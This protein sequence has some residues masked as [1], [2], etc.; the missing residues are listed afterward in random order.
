[1][2]DYYK[3]LNVNK[4]SSDKEIKKA[5]HKLALKHHPDHGGDVNKFKEINEAF[6][7]ISNQDKRKKY[8]FQRNG[9]PFNG[10]PD[11]NSMMNE[12]F[13]GS[14]NNVRQR[15][16]EKEQKD[17]DLMFRMGINL[18]QIKNGFSSTIKFQRKVKCSSC[19]GQGGQNIKACENCNGTG[20]TV[21]QKGFMIH[22]MTCQSCNGC[23]ETF[24]SI[25]KVC[26]GRGVTEQDESIEVIVKEKK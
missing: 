25:C 13:K 9:S 19:N 18:E 17:K 14:R 21:R 12:F 11:L 26:N 7:N 23:G 1:M 3:I 15:K 24:S 6:N 2:K 22:R 20:E 5:F 16:R 10:F 8:E 4:N